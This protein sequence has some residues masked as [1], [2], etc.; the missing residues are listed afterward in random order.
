MSFKFIKYDPTPG[1]KGYRGVCTVLAW[2]KILLRFKYCD[3]K[4]GKGTF[5]PCAGSANVPDEMGMDKYVSAF[6]F[7]R[8]SE[9]A[10]CETVMRQALK[11]ILRTEPSAFDPQYGAVV[12]PAANSGYVAPPPSQQT[13]PFIQRPEFQPGYSHAV[14]QMPQMPE[15]DFTQAPPDNGVPF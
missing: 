14:P 13:T 2:D 12:Q 9:D 11:Q 1:Q 10:Q 8:N 3:R 6:E 15:F 7:E 4:D 5:L